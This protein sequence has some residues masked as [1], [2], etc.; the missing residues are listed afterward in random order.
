M[1]RTCFFL[2]VYSHSRGSPAAVLLIGVG[3]L[4]L[5]TMVTAKVYTSLY[6]VPPKDTFALVCRSVFLFGWS[7]H[8]FLSFLSPNVIK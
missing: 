8:F 2:S 1:S 5:V 4:G 7:D 6:P 3:R